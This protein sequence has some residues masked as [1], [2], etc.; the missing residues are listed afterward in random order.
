MIL[1]MLMYKILDW[2]RFHILVISIMFMILM[3]TST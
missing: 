3:I 1:M 2:Y